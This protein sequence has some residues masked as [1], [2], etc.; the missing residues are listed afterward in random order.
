MK[1]FFVAIVASLF[2]TIFFALP[3]SA[4]SIPAFVKI[5]VPYPPI[6]I[7]PLQ[8][9]W[10]PAGTAMRAEGG[11]LESDSR[12]KDFPEARECSGTG[13]GFCNMVWKHGDGTIIVINT[14][15]EEYL[16]IVAISN[17]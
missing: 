1:I 3:V 11:C 17:E 9:G 10:K 2:A 6:R 5:D 14:A 15:G 4:K 16:S 7:R 13:L 12:C 8:K